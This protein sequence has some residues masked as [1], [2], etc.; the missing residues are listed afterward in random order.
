MMKRYEEAEKYHRNALE[1]YEKL[2][3]IDPDVYNKDLAPVLN[4]LAILYAENN[5][6]EAEKLF[7]QSIQLYETLT[8][9][10]M[11]DLA[12]VVH[13]LACFYYEAK[14]WNE[15]KVNFQRAVEMYEVLVQSVSDVYEKSLAGNLCNLGATY[16]KLDSLINAETYYLRALEIN[17]RL[18]L[19]N[20]K[21]MVSQIENNLHLLD[22]LYETPKF[23]SCQRKCDTSCWRNYAKLSDAYLSDNKDSIAHMFV[24]LADSYESSNRT[25]ISLQFLRHALEIYK[26]LALN[27]DEYL[28]KLA[29]VNMHLSTIYRDLENYTDAEKYAL[30]ALKNYE[31]Y[32]VNH[33]EEAALVFSAQY[34]LFTIYLVAEKYPQA[35]EM[36]LLTLK[37]YELYVV[38]D[39]EYAELK[40]ELHNIQYLLALLYQEIKKYEYAEKYARLALEGF[41]CYAE[42]LECENNI[43]LGLNILSFTSLI[44][45]KYRIAEEYAYEALEYDDVVDIYTNLAAAILLQGRFEEAKQIYMTHKEDLRDTFLEDFQALKDNNAIPKHLIGDVEKIIELLHS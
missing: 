8:P 42:E 36:G 28:S 1:C 39:D 3:E 5:N 40:F 7:L 29:E 26:E 2:Y 11:P 33:E 35:E 32:V 20:P 18:V 43:A 13:N 19:L 16:E 12:F 4:H 15:A 21:E 34:N 23:S 27:N 6:M 22:S 31:S 45:K 38:T 10:S 41:R 25:D 24:K 14:Q 30:A 37:S 17:E 9:E 44:Q